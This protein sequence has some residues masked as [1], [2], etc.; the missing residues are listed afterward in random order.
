MINTAKHVNKFAFQTIIF[1]MLLCIS[2]FRVLFAQAQNTIA[3]S[4]AD[5]KQYLVSS[6]SRWQRSVLK[7]V[8]CFWLALFLFSTGTTQA[9]VGP[10]V[11]GTNIILDATQ[12]TSCIGSGGA[13]VPGNLFTAFDNGSFGVSDTPGSTENSA[14]VNPFPPLAGA[15]YEQYVRQSMGGAGNFNFGEYSFVSN[16]VQARNAFQ[17]EAATPASPVGIVDPGNGVDGR[18]FHI[19]PE[20]ATEFPAVTIVGVPGN[21]Y[22][23]NFWVADA[24][25]GAGDLSRLDILVD[26]VPTFATP[27]IQNPFAPGSNAMDPTVWMQF[28]FLVTAPSPSF[29]V[30]L[31]INDENGN[32]IN[33]GSGR[34]IH[35]DEIA[36]MACEINEVT[37]LKTATVSPLLPDGTFNV[38]YTMIVTNSGNVTLVNSSLTD[39]LATQLGAAFTTGSGIVSPPVVTP[40]ITTPPTTLP[41]GVPIPGTTIPTSNGANFTGAPGGEDLVIAAGSNLLPGDSYQVVFTANLNAA[42]GATSLENSATTTAVSTNGIPVSDLSDNTGG[43]G[44]DGTDPTNP[45]LNQDNPTV[46]TP[47]ALLPSLAIT[48]IAGVTPPVNPDG[49]F[50]QQFTINVVNDGN[51]NLS[52]IVLTDDIEALFGNQ[53]LPSTAAGNPASGVL[54]APATILNTATGISGNL[55]FDGD[56]VGG[57]SSLIAL[58]PGAEIAPGEE[59]TITFTVE[60]D[61]NQL[62]GNENPDGTTSNSASVTGTPPGGTPLPLETDSADIPAEVEPSLGVVKSASVGAL[63]GDGTF[64]V[65]YTILVQNTGNVNL[66][67]L[68]LVDDLT[69]PTQLGSAFVSVVS[70]PVVSGTAATLPSPATYTGTGGLITGLDGFLA[71]SQNYE[72]TFT[73]NVNPN[74]ALAPSP[75]DNTATAGGTAPGATGVVMDDSNTGTDPTGTGTG[76]TPGDNPGDVVGGTGPGTPTII[77]PPPA[78]PELGV[79][80]AAGVPTLNADGTFDVVYTLLLENTGNVD[81][82]N[83]TLVDDL[84]TQ[85]TGAFTGSDATVTTGGIIAAPTVSLVTD[86][87][88]TAVVLPG[89]NAGYA[90][91]AANDGLFAPSPASILGVGD[92]ISVTFT[93]R[94]DPTVAGASFEN[95]AT[96]GGTD[97]SGVDVADDSNDGSDPASGSGGQGVPTPVTPPTPNP[98]L[99]VVKSA[100][101]GPLLGDGTFEVTYTLEIENTGDVTLSPLTLIDDLSAATQLGS[102]F[103]VIVSAPVVSPGTIS[104]GSTVP[105]TNGAA[106]LGTTAGSSI[107]IGTDGALIPGDSYLVE[108]VVNVDPNAAGAPAALSNTATAGG[109][110]PG[111]DPTDPTTAVTDDSNT[112]SDADG[113]P[114]GETPGDNPGD[115]VGD[116]VPTPL[117]PPEINPSLIVSKEVAEV[118]VDIG[119]GAFLVTYNMVIEND[120]NVDFVNLQVVDDL[121]ATIN[122]PTPNNGSVANALVTFVSGTPLTP[123][124]AYT[125]TGVNDMLLGTDPFPVGSVATITLSFEFTPDEFLGPFNNT[126]V[127][128]GTDPLG[129]VEED[130]SVNAAAPTSSA[131]GSDETSETPFTLLVPTVPISLGSFTSLPVDGGV[132]IRWVTQT[133]VANIGF[134][135]YAM[136]DDEW[137]TLNNE[138]I[139]SQGDSVS[140]QSYEFTSD[141]EAEFFSLGDL[142]V[143]GEETLH[144]PFRLGESDGSIGQ[145]RD[146][147][148]SSEQA[149]RDAKAAERKARRE[150]SQIERTQRKMEEIRKKEQIKGSFRSFSPTDKKEETSMLNKVKRSMSGFAAVALATIIPSAHAQEQSAIDWVNLATTEDGVYELSYAQLAE[151][152]VDLE[153]LPVADISLSNQGTGVPV[154]ILGGETF[155]PDSSIRFIA[156]SIDTLYTDQNIYTLSSGGNV[157]NVS[158]AATAISARAPFAISYL[159]SAKF[160]PQS[161]YSFTSPGAEPWFAKRLVSV[162]KPVSDTTQIQL[163]NV[164]AG[165]NNGFTQAKMRVNVWGANDS[166]GLNDH[167]MQISFNGRQLVDGRFDAL[168]SETFEMNLDDVVEGGNAVKLT[169]PTQEGFSLDVVN[170]NEIEVDYPRQFIAED[171]RLSF[172]STSTK[173]L[174]RGFTSNSTDESGNPSLDVVVYREDQNGDVE[175]VNNA[176]VACRRDC[177]VVFGG[178]GELANYYVS[179][180]R[181]AVSPQALIEEQDISSGAAKYLIISHPDFIGSAGNNQLEALAADLTNEMGSAAVVDVEQIYAQYSGHVFDPTAIQRY[182]KDS[183]D[184]R[185]TRYVLLVGGDVYDYRQFENQDAVSYIP[186]LYAATGRNVTFAPADAKYVDF[187]DDNV[188]EIPLGRLPVRT[189]AQ[190]TAIMSKRR[191]YLDRDYAGTALFVAD[192]FDEIQQYDF[193]S[194]ARAIGDEYLS[195]YELSTAFVDELG[196]RSTRNE[197]TS[198]INQGV[199]LTSFFGHS[200]TNQWSFDGLLTGNDAA[201]LSNVGRPTVVTQWGC[202]NTYYVS[203]NEDSMGHRFMTEGEQ[204]AVAVMGAT[205]LTNAASERA[206]AKLVFARLA[207]GERIGDAIA[208]AKQ[209]YAQTNPNDLDVLLG[210]TLLGM[211]DLFVN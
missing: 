195:N 189:T 9:Q 178:T 74:A 23:V 83:I 194:D 62:S 46:I 110:P 24:E 124:P 173:F 162:N 104:A 120:G 151:F 56:G 65:T 206:L 41:S 172:T 169:L 87:P 50:A 101:V 17:L 157:V 29:D 181:Y 60:F 48:K 180:N 4:I 114:T 34:D 208:N 26:G 95:T 142:D 199:T 54:I 7:I 107:I 75:L 69:L 112:G 205:T 64:D 103:S 159:A 126:A 148:W 141:V 193:A 31:Q 2:I 79:S 168:Q 130:N 154:Q 47:P 30:V 129:N 174:V 144:G 76:E 21:Q 155:G 166:P 94:L 67:P 163:K 137:V 98:E 161:Q 204:G 167:R 115:A 102:A 33:N 97:P 20:D 184:N 38:T 197:L 13:L 187:N 96:G 10:V 78:S 72:V 11:P 63:Q 27:V 149:E 133:E 183:H 177:T 111:A 170:V 171:N 53:F 207:N 52:N 209:E 61:A 125:G 128:S 132:L 165:G 8:T 127:A 190:L 84:E 118:P 51:V 192:E 152:G 35:I 153:G 6:T 158:S 49:T 176:E 121:T 203:P 19:D 90:G 135:L 37:A 136:V 42:A 44:V 119:G 80:K 150:A 160:A 113:D 55:N 32:P 36:I 185:G 59:I 58:A 40:L 182:I 134:N 70:Q 85:F 5:M 211:P 140:L 138:L 16:I 92:I 99:G 71:P 164:A 106:F 18:F 139:L 22:E 179:A 175:E 25:I 108:F 191:A 143:N 89:P 201:S 45:A 202:W 15:T 86:A 123:N 77:T 200:S 186:S 145:R 43:D 14:A 109:F 147:D 82:T 122:N 12:G 91:N 66:S 198:V 68:T 131:D 3:A 81:L 57:D 100:S 156:K 39:D 196:S 210:W 116:G 188:P 93:A 28:S 105:S 117:T 146:I 1:I 73:V 88:G